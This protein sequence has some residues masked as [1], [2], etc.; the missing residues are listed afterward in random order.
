MA[1]SLGQ[2]S[3]QPLPAKEL[4]FFKKVIKNYES[5]QYKNALRC[6][7]QILSQP[8]FSNHGE[9]LAMKALILDSMGKYEES[10]DLA[11]KG[12]DNDMKSYL[13]WHVYGLV[14]KTHRKYEVAIGAFK[15]SLRIDKQ[16]H[17]VMRDLSMVQLQSRDYEG[18]RDTCFS[19]LSSK[20]SNKAIWMGYAVSHHMLNDF[21]MALKTLESFKK[22]SLKERATVSE[23]SEF[24]FYQNMII[25]DSG[26]LQA[27]LEHLESNAAIFVDKLK[28][29][30][31]RGSILFNLGRFVQA[32][33][34]FINLI[35]RNPENTDYYKWVQRC[36]Q[37]E[38]ESK[39]PVRA[40]EL[41]VEIG[42]RFPK[43]NVPKINPI[44]FLEGEQ[45][46]KVL[47]PLIISYI[48]KGVPSLFK[49]LRV[50]YDNEAKVATVEKF[51][52]EK[53]EEFEKNGTKAHLDSNENEEEP[54]VL[55]WL[56]LLAAQHF[57]FL[58]LPS[59]A[60]TYAKKAVDHTPTAIDSLIVYSR[61]LK[62]IGSTELAASQL[63]IACSL[64]VG[65]RF[66]NTKCSKYLLLD[67]DIEAAGKM[68][69]KFT[70]ENESHESY[71]DEMQCMWFQF[72]YGLA[73]YK[74]CDFGNALK[75]VHQI[76][77]HFTQ[78]YAD[79][80]DFH[81]YC[82]RKMTLTGY[83]KFL[84]ME[85]NVRDHDYFEKAAALGMKTYL[86]MIDR[87]ED[88][89]DCVSKTKLTDQEKKAKK[90]EGKAEN[91]KKKDIE[92][93]NPK[94][95]DLQ[96]L[97]TPKSPLDEAIKFASSII[98]FNGT[99]VEA[100]V[101]AFEVYSK[102]QKPLLMLKAL[103]K[104]IVRG[105]NNPLT[106]IAK[107]KFL[108]Y[109]KDQ[110]KE[111]G[112]LKDAVDGIVSKLFKETDPSTFNAQYFSNNQQNSLKLKLAQIRCDYLLGKATTAEA[113]L[114]LLNLIKNGPSS[115]Y[116][117][118][119]KECATLLAE[120]SIGSLIGNVSPDFVSQLQST[121]S[122]IYPE[123][124]LFKALA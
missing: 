81:G 55:L 34:V 32:E 5:R 59:K 25:Q 10:L 60:L 110:F 107:L 71:L 102:A 48:R 33:Q 84:K 46:E 94:N 78:F 89:V 80:F 123:A 35:S 77:T 75:K 82:M 28:Y 63:E 6:A 44:Y 56:Y 49:L 83:V 3:N 104:A 124:C 41:Y 98:A 69:S 96:F 67:G 97:V 112:V 117:L 51:V 99:N 42:E 21:D 120:V 86:R 15:M 91:G 1:P 36:R 101:L 53:I 24:T 40:N 45:F 17:Q 121:L 37:I 39:D 61:C 116:R 79:Q 38:D 103:Q 43:A 73:A 95:L 4:N 74:K 58:Q 62:H 20:A 113:S 87:P 68:A 27:A 54:D 109:Y 115:L 114:T 7:K 122:S 88:F 23:V 12:V 118:S 90:K 64:E 29:H 72:D 16:N 105:P 52:T 2:T 22:S 119:Y 26:N 31:T 92:T 47:F 11:K 85:D 93:I 100:A 70:R 14:L 50:F 57:D 9:T 106:H 30:L 19:L 13:C 8:Q 18:F 108:I 65:D 111:E 66:L 76:D